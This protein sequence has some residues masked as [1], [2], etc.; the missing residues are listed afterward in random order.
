LLQ[1]SAFASLGANAF[2]CNVIVV[3]FIFYY[4]QVYGVPLSDVT[5]AVFVAAAFT[6][7]LLLMLSAGVQVYTLY[8]PTEKL[9]S[10]VIAIEVSSNRLQFS[11][12]KCYFSFANTVNSTLLPSV[13]SCLKRQ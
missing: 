13:D 5:P 4:L 12:Q 9:A 3:M 10:V 6:T 7:L 11:T 1:P 8:S 2:A